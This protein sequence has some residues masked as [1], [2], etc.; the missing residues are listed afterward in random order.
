MCLLGC[1]AGAIG[2]AEPSIDV[3]LVFPS[4]RAFLSSMT[5]RVDVYAGTGTDDQSPEATCLRL[6]VATSFPPPGLRPL[7]TSGVQDVCAFSEGSVRIADVGVGRRVLWAGALD[8]AAQLLVAGCAIVDLTENERDGDG[9]VDTLDLQLSTLPA[10]PPSPPSC[11]TVDEKCKE[12]IE[13]KPAA[14]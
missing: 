3:R 12:K 11:A 8:E 10:F 13:C 4:E 1:C 7:A 5:A 2:C 9:I 6:A 14:P